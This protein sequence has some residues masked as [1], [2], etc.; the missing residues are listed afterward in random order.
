V[1]AQD[2]QG[3]QQHGQHRGRADGGTHQQG[4]GQEPRPRQVLGRIAEGDQD[5]QLALGIQLQ[6]D[7]VARIKLGLPEHARAA[8][9][10]LRGRL[11]QQVLDR[12]FLAP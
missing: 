4:I 1:I 6:L 10:A 8:Q 11:G 9:Q 3:G 7:G 5:R 2:A 12:T